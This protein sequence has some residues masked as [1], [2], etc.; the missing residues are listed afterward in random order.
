MID[1]FTV[2]AQIVNFLILVA[3]LKKFLYGPIMNAM[4]RRENDMR[5][6]MEEAEQR[7]QEAGRQKEAFRRKTEE[8]KAE[9]Q[10]R[11]EQ[12]DRDAEERRK[13]LVSEARAQVD[14][15]REHWQKD[16]EREREQ[17]ADALR[18]TVGR[19]AV[20]IARRALADLA[21]ED[22]ESRMA[23]CLTQRLEQM[24]DEA[25]K[26]FLEALKEEEGRVV[27]RGASSMSDDA[28]DRLKHGLQ[29]AFD[30]ELRIE[31]TERDNGGVG[32]DIRIGSRK[33]AWTLDDYLDR[34]DDELEQ[35]LRRPGREEDE[36]RVSE[37]PDD[38]EEPS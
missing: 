12:A 25:R 21:G 22:L 26:P 27:V 3:L 32:V 7:R 8:L 31:R 9:E 33:L 34:V 36:D 10:K 37:T 35:I 30:H 4:D 1:W 11:L 28:F 24:D 20:R 13:E 18:E 17:F 15:M 14:E 6:R 23:D 29:S 5:E 2:A 16:V 38:E 19:Q